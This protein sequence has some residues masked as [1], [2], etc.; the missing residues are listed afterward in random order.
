MKGIY[1]DAEAPVM[2][3]VFA[4]VHVPGRHRSRYPETNVYVVD[5]AELA[6]AQAEPERHCY[7]ACLMG[8][9]RSSEGVRLYYLVAWL[10]EN[11]IP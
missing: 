7:A 3:E 6:I 5:S 4:V 10:D 1:L 11:H 9:A 2:T 8:P